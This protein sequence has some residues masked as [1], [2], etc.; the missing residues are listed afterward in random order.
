MD[1]TLYDWKH[2]CIDDQGEIKFTD[3][4]GWVS[5]TEYLEDATQNL[6][7]TPGS[8]LQA[9]VDKLLAPNLHHA[10]AKTYET[11]R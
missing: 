3:T 8:T 9:E 10:L 11:L 6:E 5:P 7:Q 2:L 1:A 4:T